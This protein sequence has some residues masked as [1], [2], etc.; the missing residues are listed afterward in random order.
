VALYEGARVEG[1]L[2]PVAQGW[3]RP[4]TG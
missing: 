4:G 2:L 1:D 3:D